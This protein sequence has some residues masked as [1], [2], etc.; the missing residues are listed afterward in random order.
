LLR[1]LTLGAVLGSFLDPVVHDIAQEEPLDGDPAVAF[2]VPG[3]LGIR[4]DRG[5]NLGLS[6]LLV[7]LQPGHDMAKVPLEDR[8][9]AA[10]AAKPSCGR[11]DGDG[12]SRMRR[13]SIPFQVLLANSCGAY[14]PCIGIPLVRF[15]TGAALILV[16]RLRWR[17]GR[18]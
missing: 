13:G 10:D 1:G 18:G 8:T 12:A 15:L 4:F 11:S 17:T 9:E 3:R 16:G 6:E 14:L 2:A 7:L 5:V